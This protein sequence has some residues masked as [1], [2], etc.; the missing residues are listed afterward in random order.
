MAMIQLI[1]LPADGLN[2]DAVRHTS[3]STS[4]VMSSEREGSPV[5]RRSGP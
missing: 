5:I 4:P 2:N 3:I 1:P